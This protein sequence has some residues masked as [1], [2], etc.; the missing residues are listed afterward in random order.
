MAKQSYGRIQLCQVPLSLWPLVL[1]ALQHAWPHAMLA[2]QLYR[3]VWPS[4]DNIDRNQASLGKSTSLNASTTHAI[5]LLFFFSFAIS[6]AVPC[7]CCSLRPPALLFFALLL[8]ECCC[9]GRYCCHACCGWRIG[10]GKFY[11]GCMRA[12]WLVGIGEHLLTW[13]RRYESTIWHIDS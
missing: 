12:P 7:S 11:C 8:Y 9:D 3:K 2:G 10:H 6:F 5:F 1:Q 4:F 13:G